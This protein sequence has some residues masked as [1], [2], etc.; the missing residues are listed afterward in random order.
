VKQGTQTVPEAV[1]LIA[2]AAAMISAMVVEA[3]VGCRRHGQ[4]TAPLWRRIL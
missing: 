3:A 4:L 1:S 2:A